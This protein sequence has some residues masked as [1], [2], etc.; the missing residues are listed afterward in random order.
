MF[1]DKMKEENKEAGE[2]KWIDRSQG[3]SDAWISFNEEKLAEI[4]N[5]L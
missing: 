5:L 1:G 3:I 2:F 4:T